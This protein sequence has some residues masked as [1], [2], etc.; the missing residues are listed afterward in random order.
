M[1]DGVAK[2]LK[3]Y[4]PLGQDRRPPSGILEAIVSTFL[5]SGWYFALTLHFLFS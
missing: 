5:L 4:I 3:E 2:P 1:I